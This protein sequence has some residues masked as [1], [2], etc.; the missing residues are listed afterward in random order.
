MPYKKIVMGLSACVIVSVGVSFFL[1]NDVDLITSP[2]GEHPPQNATTNRSSDETPFAKQVD[3]LSHT[4]PDELLESA[5]I[6]QQIETAMQSYAEISKYP[7][8]SQPIVSEAHVN[9]FINA[10]VPESSLPYP[11]DGL[12][13]PIQ[14]SLT[15]EK[16][17]YFLGDAVNASISLS[18]IPENAAVSA[19]S[20]L[21]SISGDI[22]AESDTEFEEDASTQKTMKVA[23]D[24]SA[25]NTQEWPL[26]VNLGAYIDVNGHQLFISAPFRINTATATFESVG[27]SEAIAEN[28]IIPVNLNVIL[29]GYYYVA[30]ILYS[31]QSNKPLVHL[32]TEGPL[33][34]GLKSLNLSAHIQ[35]LKKG[36]DEGP[37]LLKNIRVERWSDEIIQMDI[38]G[39]VNEESFTVEGYAFDAF[40]DIPYIDPLNAE[41]I[42]LMGGLSSL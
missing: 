16:Y 36:G 28:L 18:D 15:L 30:A 39:Q 7:P 5:E 24:T 12:D 6:K 25:Y 21:M 8:N 34:A 14:L 17:N 22:L 1:G 23:F 35:A 3:T 29:P 38:A 37:Y 40:K 41:R 27:Y 32:E 9:S 10:S 26:E 2:K 4:A 31:Q 13:T 20:V 11:I 42:K 19:R 33:N